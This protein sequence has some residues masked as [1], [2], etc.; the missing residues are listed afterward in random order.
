VTVSVCGIDEDDS[1]ILTCEYD[2]KG[3]ASEKK[4]SRIIPVIKVPRRIFW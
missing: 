4:V 2:L 3:K 1:N